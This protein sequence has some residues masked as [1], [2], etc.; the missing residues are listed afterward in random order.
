VKAA[1][2]QCGAGLDSAVR[3]WLGVEQM[4]QILGGDGYDVEEL[5]PVVHKMVD[6]ARADCKAGEPTAGGRFFKAVRLGSL[7]G[8][9]SSTEEVDLTNEAFDA[10]KEC[11]SWRLVSAASLEVS[12]GGYPLDEHFSATGM[13]R[14][15]GETI[16]PMRVTTRNA[17]TIPSKFLSMLAQGFGSAMGVAVPNDA[18]KCS[19]SAFGPSA[20]RV[21]AAS[22]TGTAGAV[23]PTIT[24]GGLVAPAT[25]TCGDLHWDDPTYLAFLMP[26]LMP[27][28]T[29]ADLGFQHAFTEAEHDGFTWTYS[30][31]V[32]VPP[33][34]GI[35]GSES[36]VLQLSPVATLDPNP[37]AAP[38]TAGLHDWGTGLR[39][40]MS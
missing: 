22:A 1:A 39:A 37:L 31:T 19:I 29:I 27:G 35:T 17:D 16:I 12:I 32:D 11:T 10:L 33:M 28:I 5:S 3:E 30:A 14:K 6:C 38:P 26:A 15:D 13:V 21:V 18:V 23:L 34:S 40:A 7:L 20:A 2:S 24:F 25:I 36:L 8:V 9:F 4:A